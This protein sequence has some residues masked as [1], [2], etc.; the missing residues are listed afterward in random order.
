MQRK[1]F[2]VIQ[3]GEKALQPKATNIRSTVH[4]SSVKQ[5]T[6]KKVGSSSRKR[7]TSA[8][9]ETKK[10]RKHNPAT[11]F[12]S[13]DVQIK[14][15]DQDNESVKSADGACS[16]ETQ[17]GDPYPHGRLTRIDEEDVSL[18]LGDFDQPPQ[19]TSTPVLCSSACYDQD[20]D[21]SPLPMDLLGCPPITYYSP[22]AF[23]Y[24]NQGSFRDSSPSQYRFLQEQDKYSRHFL[25]ADYH[26]LP[27][28]PISMVQQPAESFMRVN[29]PAGLAPIKMQGAP[30]YHLVHPSAV[31][32]YQRVP[33]LG[34]P[35][36][37]QLRLP[38]G[39][40]AASSNST[41]S[42][43]SSGGEATYRSSGQSSKRSTGAG[44]M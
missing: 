40:V 27:S 5:Q 28:Q 6:S 18:K 34:Y 24:H 21:V 22:G 33:L 43:K 13:E 41:S 11:V 10:K 15:V 3:D 42:Y 29:Y 20:Q 32:G 26:Y 12:E 7:R 8:A 35:A 1:R 16:T 14:L 31:P 30:A 4:D 19:S 38:G 44:R 37:P 9:E 39:S 25:G 2:R 17:L 23:P 36:T